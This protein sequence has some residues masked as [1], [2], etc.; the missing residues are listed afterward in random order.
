MGGMEHMQKP[1]MSGMDEAQQAYMQS[2]MKMGP[3]MMQGMMARDA[4]VAFVCGMIAHHQGAIDMAEVELKHGDNE[5]A[6][7]M[8]QKVIDAQKKEIVE[9]TQWIDANAK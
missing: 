3:A 8:A 2:M 4:D 1:D 5:Q 6:K 7:Q 9:F